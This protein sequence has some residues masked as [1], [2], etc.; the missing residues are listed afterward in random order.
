VS[1]GH[2]LVQVDARVSRDAGAAPISTISSDSPSTSS[3]TVTSVNPTVF[4]TPSSLYVGVYA[5]AGLAD[6][7]P[8]AG[9]GLQIAYTL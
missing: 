6:G 3:V 2:A 9:A 4:S 8:D 5:V 7:S 1:A